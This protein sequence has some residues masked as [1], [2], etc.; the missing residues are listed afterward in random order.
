MGILIQMHVILKT[1]TNRKRTI[2]KSTLWLIVHFVCLSPDVANAPS[3]RRHLVLEVQPHPW[4][5]PLPPGA[6]TGYMLPSPIPDRGSRCSGPSTDPAARKGCWGTAAFPRPPDQ[7][8]A[9]ACCL[10]R[11]ILPKPDAGLRAEPKQQQPARDR[12]PGPSRP[13]VFPVA[14]RAGCPQ[15]NAPS[16]RLR[17][18]GLW[19]GG[20][21][22]NVWR[23][24]VTFW[25]LFFRY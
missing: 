16:L 24:L 25:S 7:P 1:I 20:T 5:P 12:N 4:A 10:C 6:A 3:S 18:W 11:Q 22:I 9:A 8:R 17:W 23:R 13:L 21:E 19:G 15:G 14:K 2:K